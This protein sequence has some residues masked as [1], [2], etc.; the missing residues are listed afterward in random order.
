MR[1]P[2]RLQST[3]LIL[4]EKNA[5]LFICAMKEVQDYYFHKAKAEGYPARSVYKLQ[6]LDQKFKLLRKGAKVLDLGAAPGSWTLGCAKKV[7]STGFV[8]SCDLQIASALFPS[9][10]I[11][12]CENIFELSES[13][14][15]LL[16]EKG[17]FDCVLSDMA[18]ST[19]G[20]RFTDQARSCELARAAFEIACAQLKNGGH[21][22]AKIFMGS[23][24]KGLQEEMRGVFARANLF[25]PKSSRSESKEIFLLGL[26]FR[27]KT[28][29]ARG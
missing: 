8:V 7:G 14:I 28:E 12:M 17:P 24:V 1:L 15:R 9:N 6:E 20:S 13:F 21:F 25:K 29:T 11:F 18:P 5:I 19:T 4:I 22:V 3:S 2:C 16:A 10:V 26:D 23:D 27:G